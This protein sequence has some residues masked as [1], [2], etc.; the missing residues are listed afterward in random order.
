MNCTHVHTMHAMQMNIYYTAYMFDVILYYSCCDEEL[1]ANKKKSFCFLLF[2]YYCDA[3]IR[4]S[5]H[6]VLLIHRWSLDRSE[7]FMLLANV[8]H[9]YGAHY[10]NV[11]VMVLSACKFSSN[12]IWRFLFSYTECVTEKQVSTKSHLCISWAL[13]RNDLM[14][15]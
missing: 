15:A 3:P 7:W 6:I 5:M 8:S 9:G 13:A 1:R 4:L 11:A 10:N 12:H 2:L 14:F